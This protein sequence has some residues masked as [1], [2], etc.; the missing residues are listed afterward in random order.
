MQ[1]SSAV[2]SRRQMAMKGDDSSSAG[3]SP[4]SMIYRYPRPSTAA[5]GYMGGNS[6]ING[7]ESSRIASLHAWDSNRHLLGNPQYS[8]AAKIIAR[9]ASRHTDAPD[10]TYKGRTSAG[11]R[12]STADSSQHKHAAK[13]QAT[14]Y[15]VWFNSLKGNEYHAK[16][17][18]SSKK[19]A[20]I[21]SSHLQRVE[22][23]V[24]LLVATGALRVATRALVPLLTQLCIVIWST[25]HAVGMQQDSQEIS[26]AIAVILLS[27][28][29]TLD[30]VL[31]YVFDTRVEEPDTGLPNHFPQASNLNLATV[32]SN[33]S[34][35]YIE[36]QNQVRPPSLA[37]LRNGVHSTKRTSAGA[38]LYSSHCSHHGL[39]IQCENRRIS[40]HYQFHETSGLVARPQTPSFARL[41]YSKRPLS[42]RSA[43]TGH[44]SNGEPGMLEQK[45]MFNTDSLNICKASRTSNAM[46]SDTL[47]GSEH[48]EWS[49]MDSC[50][51]SMHCDTTRASQYSG[52]GAQHRRSMVPVL[53][54]W[55]EVELEDA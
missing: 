5:L 43:D 55:E 28:Q 3:S 1:H 19:Q 53:S 50:G 32:T 30:M 34:N 13:G 49:Q 41:P 27:L 16:G 39:G 2:V 29:G 54:G 4:A 21:S 18:G 42:R 51:I 10:S 20:A 22:N 15:H 14:K 52:T 7:S 45:F 24:K 11:T 12:P 46:Q 48:I 36:Q 37:H 47:N 8:P 26:Y 17:R 25:I 6:T 44:G 40:G 31:Y 38:Q 9:Q 23:R 33:S 35:A